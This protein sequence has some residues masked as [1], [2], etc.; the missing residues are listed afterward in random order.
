[1]VA[2][3]ASSKSSP[4]DLGLGFENIEEQAEFITFGVSIP[5]VAG[6]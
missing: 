5:W 4:L 2:F 1:M 6:I 3:Q